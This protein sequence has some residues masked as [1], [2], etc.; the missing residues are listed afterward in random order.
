[1]EV[2]EKAKNAHEEIDEIE[3][4]RNSAYDILIRRKTFVD[5]VCVIDDIAAEEEASSNCVNEV[6]GPAKRYEYAN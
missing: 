4:K 1:M 2:V 6:H 5:H 3:V